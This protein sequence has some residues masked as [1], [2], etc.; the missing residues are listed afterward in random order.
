[1]EMLA[2]IIDSKCA[3]N[4]IDIGALYRKYSFT[5]TFTEVQ[6]VLS[7]PRRQD[8]LLERKRFVVA[9]AAESSAPAS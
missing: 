3:C 7:G 2:L 6:E 4:S 9:S 1:M 8:T 5:K